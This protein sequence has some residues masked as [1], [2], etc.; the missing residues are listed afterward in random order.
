MNNSTHVFITSCVV[1]F[2][3]KSCPLGV[4]SGY[5]LSQLVLPC[6]VKVSGLV[7]TVQSPIVAQ[8]I[9]PTLL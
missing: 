7:T 9:A 2:L 3:K 6:A 5:F 1:V 4:R 8:I